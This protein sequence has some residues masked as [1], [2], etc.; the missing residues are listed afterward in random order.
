[1]RGLPRTGQ[2]LS[3][4]QRARL[5]L[6]RAMLADAPVILLDE[7]LANV[8][9]ESQAVI[10]DALAELRGQRTCIAVTHQLA[11]ARLADR[12]LTIEDRDVR[13]LN[14]DDAVHSPL[15]ALS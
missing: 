3:G 6:A 1:M 12:V 14:R 9:P 8:D 15:R 11:L 7:P 13:E 5:S 2:N 10:L 4:G